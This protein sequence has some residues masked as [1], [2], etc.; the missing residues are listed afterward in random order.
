[1]EKSNEGIKIMK[2]FVDIAI[3]PFC[4]LLSCIVETNDNKSISIYF[5]VCAA[6]IAT[7]KFNQYTKELK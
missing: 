2:L 4:L 1:M 5:A 6:I 3:V 7:N